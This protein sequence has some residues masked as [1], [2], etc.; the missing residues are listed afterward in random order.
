MQVVFLFY[1]CVA[2]AVPF[3]FRDQAWSTH[4]QPPWSH[5]GTGL[6]GHMAGLGASHGTTKLPA[7]SV[8]TESSSG[9][10]QAKAKCLI[11]KIVAQQVSDVH[12]SINRL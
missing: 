9:P 1:S 7:G 2:P 10:G 12:N 4:N 8:G 6:L 3:C 11:S 5:T